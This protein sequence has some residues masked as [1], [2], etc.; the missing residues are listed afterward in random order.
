MCGASGCHST[1][2]RRTTIQRWFAICFLVGATW[3]MSVG[4]TL[5]DTFLLSSGGSVDGELLNPDQSPRETYIVRTVSGGQ[6][7]LDQS[8]VLRII[9]KSDA[10]L[11]YEQ[12]LPKMPDTILGNWQMAEWCRQKKLLDQRQRHLKE[13]VRRDPA[14]EK[15]RLALGFSRVEGKWVKADQWMQQQGYVRHGG[16]WRTRQE[17]AWQSRQREVELLQLRWKRQLKLLRDRLDG[18]DGEKA[19]ADILAIRDVMAAPALAELFEDEEDARLRRLY[20]EVLGRLNS[21][22]AVKALIRGVLH[23]DDAETRLSCLDQLEGN[24]RRS[25]VTAFIAGLKSKDNRVVNRAAVGLRRLNDPSAVLPLVDAL[26]TNHLFKIGR[27][28]P[29]QMSASFGGPSGGGGLGGLSMGGGPK[30][31]EKELDNIEVLNALVSLVE[32]AN[33]QYDKQRW[34]QW[35]AETH[36][37][38]VA[39]LR[40]DR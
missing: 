10:E 20:I 23:D 1:R 21:S 13:I 8:Q 28:S 2:S 9:A 11:R 18:R 5:A 14:H 12:L 35:Y 27:G 26:T 22:V 7:T 39:S 17:L 19:K 15:A 3:S 32:G 25:A 36:A 6:L 16:A 24:G 38:N 29:G 31:V 34:L 30:T 40:R 4:H 37:P 33:F